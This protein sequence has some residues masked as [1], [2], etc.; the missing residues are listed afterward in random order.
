M[1]LNIRQRLIAGFAVLVLLLSCAVGITIWEVSGVKSGTDKIVTLRIPTS[2]ASSNMLTQIQAS[3]ANLRGWMLTGNDNFKTG[4]AEVWAGIDEVAGDMDA[5]SATWTVPANV[6]KWNEFKSILAEFRTAQDQVEAIAKSADEQP[7]TKMLVVQAAPIAGK[8]VSQITAII[9]QE[10]TLTPTPDRRQ[11]LGAMADVRGTLGLSLANIRAY[12]L[13]GEEKFVEGFDNLWSKNDKRFADLNSMALLMTTD[14]KVA[15]ESFSTNRELFSPLPAQMF[16]IRGSK[17]WNMANYMLVTEAAPRAGKLLNILLGERDENGVRQGGMVVNQKA[18]LLKDSDAGAAATSLLMNVQW[19]LLFIGIVLGVVITFF[20]ARSIVNPVNNMTSAMSELANGNLDVNV[21]SQDSTDEIG[22]MAKAVQIF[23]D[24]G[25]ENKRMAAEV[26]AAR[27]ASEE[28]EQARRDE[29]EQQRLQK[30]A[31]EKA[32]RDASEARLNALN[33]ITSDFEIKV[34]DIVG[35]LS[36]AA[37]EMLSSSSQLSVTA[38]TT[39]EQSMTVASASEQASNNVSTVSAAAEELSS[40]INEISRQVSE[41]STMAAEAVKEAQNS[42]D[43]VQGLVTSA[44]QIGEVVELITDIAEQTNLL[45]LNATIE[46]ARAGDA[47][48]G[49]AVVA[50]EVKNLANQTARA[51]EQISL[52]ISEI[53]NATE[54]AAGSIEG[55]ST[56][57]NRVDNIAG[58]I[59]SAVEEQSA[60]TQEI[61]RNVE[62][63]AAGTNEVSSS[64]AN[65]TQAAGE[66]GT[67]ASGIKLSAENLAQQSDLLAGEVKSFI[68]RVKAA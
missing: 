4:R 37:E 7:A 58:N 9:D 3:L 15:F 64:I 35:S 65:V 56:T 33:T 8:M 66:T 41:S 63:A 10:M 23:K 55:I 61:A 52:Q 22:E 1:N 46:A 20:T 53:Q 5:L 26:E 44:K 25:I 16:A 19:A 2:Q 27:I 47:G 12:L 59:A 50:A 14:Q 57:I 24:A 39:S 34:G 51:T 62:Q 28:S 36:G 42:H 48:K 60:A 17:K 21:P 18:L 6:E 38:D 30:E 29:V 43:A 31:A 13:T 32:E 11:L 54:S 67:A 49:F 68:D 45:A 40:S